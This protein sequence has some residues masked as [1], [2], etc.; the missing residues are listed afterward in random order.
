MNKIAWR[1]RWPGHSAELLVTETVA[2][3]LSAHRQ[4]IWETE[5]GGQL[6]VDLND[7]RGLVLAGVT[8][9]H[10][11][12]RAE[13]AWLELNPERCRQ[14]IAHANVRGWRLVGYWH[15]HPQVMP[16]I[17]PTDVASFVEFANRHAGPLP[18]PLAV[19]VGKPDH[20]LGIRAWSI[21]DGQ[22]KEGERVST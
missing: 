8:S 12:D 14:E 20:C 6:F 16:K 22:P 9:P 19:I 13:R 10:P 11:A 18:F 4:R 1:W 17:S 21:R 15:T 2:Q 5:R 7:R 3:V